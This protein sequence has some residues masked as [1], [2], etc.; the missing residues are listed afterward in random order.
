MFSVALAWV[1]FAYCITSRRWPGRQ[2]PPASGVSWFTCHV[3]HLFLDTVRKRQFGILLTM[4]HYSRKR[5]QAI[6]GVNFPHGS[7]LL[8]GFSAVVIVTAPFSLPAAWLLIHAGSVADCA[9]IIL[10]G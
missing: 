1:S 2:L 8:L 6:V 9:E 5:Q 7:L 4:E 3:I 10:R